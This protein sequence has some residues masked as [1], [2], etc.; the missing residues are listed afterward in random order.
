MSS[1]DLWFDDL[2]APND[3]SAKTLFKNRRPSGLEPEGQE[4]DYAP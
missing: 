2:Y 1:E 4:G 3:V